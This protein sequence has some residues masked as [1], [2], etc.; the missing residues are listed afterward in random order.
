VRD[1]ASRH[2]APFVSV[3]MNRFG[4]PDYCRHEC[5]IGR[6]E[7]VIAARVPVFDL[8]SDCLAL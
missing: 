8:R 2:A 5:Y 3:H 1:L 6:G 7:H 4:F